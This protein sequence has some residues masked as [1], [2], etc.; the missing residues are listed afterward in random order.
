MI[1]RTNESKKKGENGERRNNQYSKITNECRCSMS[2]VVDN[3]KKKCNKCCWCAVEIAV[4]V[5]VYQVLQ[6][7]TWEALLEVLNQFKAHSAASSLALL[8]F[9][10]SYQYRAARV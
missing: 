3:C 2:L 10:P 6:F 7:R 9:F 8:R 1:N 4:A 5:M